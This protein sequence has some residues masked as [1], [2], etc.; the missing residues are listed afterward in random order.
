MPPPRSRKTLSPSGRTGASP[1]QV[2]PSL[3][4]VAGFLLNQ[5]A[6]VIR[7]R[8]AQAI[9]HEGVQPRQLGLLF[10]LRETG[11][12]SQQRLGELLGM[13]RTT[14]M[15]L[16]AALEAVGLVAR[17]DDPADRRAYRLRLTTKGQEVTRRVS[18]AVADVE[19]TTLKALKAS[20]R[21]LLKALLLKVLE[22]V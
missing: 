5:V 20:E 7:E 2:P 3:A 11:V 22:G 18:M 1:E 12:H 8:T 9:H 4:D 13:D 14:T 15:Q 17:D 16:V 6:A 19:R 21:R 10:L